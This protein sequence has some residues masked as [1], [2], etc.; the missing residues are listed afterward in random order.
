MFFSRFQAKL[1]PQKSGQKLIPITQLSSLAAGLQNKLSEYY[2]STTEVNKIVIPLHINN[3]KIVLSVISLAQ[4]FQRIG[5]NQQQETNTEETRNNNKAQRNEFQT[6]QC[7]LEPR[8]LSH[9]TRNMTAK[10]LQIK[11][12]P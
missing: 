1:R 9:F 3:N 12:K 10:I 7:K 4:N 8:N 2:Y 5:M 11:E 6:F